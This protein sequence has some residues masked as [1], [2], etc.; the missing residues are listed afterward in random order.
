MNEYI[1]HQWS[2]TP[3]RGGVVYVCDNCGVKIDS[4]YPTSETEGSSGVAKEVEE[5]MEWLDEL[6][7]CEDRT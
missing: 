7:P 1:K 5:L 4:H 3:Y 2:R 6:S